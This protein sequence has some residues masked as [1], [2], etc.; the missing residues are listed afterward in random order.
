MEN[1]CSCKGMIPQSLEE[2]SDTLQSP[3]IGFGLH[4]HQYNSGIS[5]SCRSM[6]VSWEMEEEQGLY[7]PLS[8]KAMEHAVCIKTDRT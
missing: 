3:D 8:E 6:C 5:E 1:A 2:A 7:L 4:T